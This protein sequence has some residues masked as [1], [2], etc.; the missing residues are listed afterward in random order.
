ML[1]IGVALVY[2]VM[3]AQFESLLHPFV[4]MFS[5]PFAFVG[6][7]FFL[8][9]FGYTLSVVTFIGIVMLVGIVVK[10]AIVLVDCINLL[11][12]RE[13]A[14]PSD[15]GRGQA[16]AAPRAN[17]HRDDA[18]RPRPA[19]DGEGRRGGDDEAIGHG[20]DRGTERIDPRDA[21]TG[22]GHIQ[23]LRIGE[24]KARG[25]G[26]RAVGLAGGVREMKAVLVVFNETIEP[27]VQ[28]ALK[29]AGI[30]YYT[31]FPQVLGTGPGSGPRLGDTVWPGA[32]TALLAVAP[33]ALATALVEKIKE[34]RK[35]MAD[36][37]LRAF[38]WGLEGMV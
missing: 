7:A 35:Q 11:R 36:A 27:E 9:A 37:G 13:L 33:E 26:D 15:H 23:S 18:C 8:Y 28:D 4:I 21:G 16:Q 30:E 3:A 22:A 20:G 19:C 2:M 29:S 24:G 17:D 31:K 1:I 14:Q 10:N 12:A 38:W 6:V 25:T 32:N 5:V 34:L